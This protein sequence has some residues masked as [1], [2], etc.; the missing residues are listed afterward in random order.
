MITYKHHILQIFKKIN[1]LK[2]LMH[3]TVHRLDLHSK[4]CTSTNYNLTAM[5]E[6][7]GN[8]NIL[9]YIYQY[10]VA[11]FKQSNS[12]AGKMVPCHII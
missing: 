2:I 7:Y 4:A 3:C 12:T 10:N 8:L 5:V 1:D 11:T 9:T 6:M